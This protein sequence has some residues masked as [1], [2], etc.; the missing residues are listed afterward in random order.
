MQILLMCG[1][2]VI[3]SSNSTPRFQ[4]IADGATAE[5]PTGKVLM[6]TLLPL[7]NY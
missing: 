5:S 2:R 6:L 7:T 4:A 1:K 3:F